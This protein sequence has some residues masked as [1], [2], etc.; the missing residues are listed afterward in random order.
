MNSVQSERYCDLFYGNKIDKEFL[1]WNFRY[2]LH[3]LRSQFLPRDYRSSV[4]HLENFARWI[5]K[6]IKLFVRPAVFSCL[7]FTMALYIIKYNMLV[8]FMYL[9]HVPFYG[10]ERVNLTVYVTMN[11][12]SVSLLMFK[13]WSNIQN[14]RAH[15]FMYQ[16]NIFFKILVSN[17][18]EVFYL[19]RL[20]L[21]FWCIVQVLCLES[22]NCSM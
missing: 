11:L 6:L 21:L 22:N 9:M 7:T 5:Q 8:L 4:H 19:F 16:N 15:H 2:V 14:V 18:V 3:Y 10:F 17:R 1:F 13:F 12:T 20:Y